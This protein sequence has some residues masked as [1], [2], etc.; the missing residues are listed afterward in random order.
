[1]E[2]PARYLLAAIDAITGASGSPESA[3][4]VIG[5]LAGLLSAP[6][7]HVGRRTLARIQALQ[8]EIQVL[9]AKHSDDRDSLQRSFLELY[10][11][12]SIN[13]WSPLLGLIPAVVEVALIVL[14]YVAIVIPNALP[15]PV[16]LGWLSDLS[17]R[18]PRFV[19]AG[20]MGLLLVVQAR[21]NILSNPPRQNLLKLLLHIAVPF[22]KFAFAAVLPSGV[23]IAWLGYSAVAATT[24][25]LSAAAA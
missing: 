5:V 22:A 8:P 12:H 15:A 25:H 7:S 18:D 4:L 3:L 16:Y 10:R 21:A 9:K 11:R 6:F 23:L 13:P 1:M 24:Q 17:S 20:S 2:A 14:L 19:L